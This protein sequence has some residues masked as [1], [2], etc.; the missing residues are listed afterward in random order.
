[1]F[2]PYND[3][4]SY[5]VPDLIALSKTY[6]WKAATAAFIQ[7]DT[8]GNPSW[9]GMPALNQTSCNPPSWNTCKTQA[10]W[11]YTNLTSYIASGGKLIISQG[12]E[13]GTSQSSPESCVN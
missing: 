11:I 3:M 7:S 1:M 12:G 13:S 4:G 2:A 8:Q 9:A 10:Q 6:G 5:P